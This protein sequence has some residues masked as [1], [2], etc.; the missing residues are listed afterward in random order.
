MNYRQQLAIDS[1]RCGLASQRPELGDFRFAIAQV[2]VLAV[3]SAQNWPDIHVG[4]RGGISVPVPSYPETGKP[5]ETA[6]DAAIWG[7][8]LLSKLHARQ[9][10]SI[11]SASTISPLRPEGVRRDGAPPARSWRD[12]ADYYLRGL[13]FPQDRQLIAKFSGAIITCEVVDELCRTYQ[14]HRNFEGYE[15]QRYRT[16]AD[17]L[18]THRLTRITRDNLVSIVNQGVNALGEAYGKNLISAVTKALWMMKQ[19]PVAIYDKKAR[20]GLSACSL[21]PGERNY[22]I[23][24]GSWFAFYDRPDTQSGIDDAVSWL[25]S[26][27]SAQEILR[28]GKLQ[29]SELEQF[30]K[31][32][33]LRNRI[34]DMRLASLGGAQDFFG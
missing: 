34:A 25:P 5:G 8:R 32:E 33:M 30:T 31:S 17:F 10:A 6:L 4:P 26:S 7:D 24:C 27:Q 1:I 14:V 20:N 28:S 3:L 22:R 18:N 9:G 11:A 23:Y 2:G 16:F 21:L 29:I 19:H 13:W 12:C 15:T